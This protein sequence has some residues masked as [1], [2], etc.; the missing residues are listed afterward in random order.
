MQLPQKG[1]KSSKNEFC[2][3]VPFCGAAFIL[4]W[5]TKQSG[6]PGRNTFSKRP[7]KRHLAWKTKQSQKNFPLLGA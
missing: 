7:I 1:T 2:A 6:A 3:F 5:Y 4:A